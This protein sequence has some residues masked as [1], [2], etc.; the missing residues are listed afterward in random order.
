MNQGFKQFVRIIIFFS[1]CILYA[2]DQKNEHKILFCEKNQYGEIVPFIEPI[3]LVQNQVDQMKL[4]K[5]LIELK[6]GF[7]EINESISVVVEDNSLKETIKK[8]FEHVYLPIVTEFIKIK[9]KEE[10]DY[11]KIISFIAFIKNN[12]NE[13]NYELLKNILN[14]SEYLQAP[15]T[16][17]RAFA[18]ICYDLKPDYLLKKAE[19]LKIIEK[20][21]YAKIERDEQ[22]VIDSLI[23]N[24]NLLISLNDLP[25]EI[26]SSHDFINKALRSIDGIKELIETQYK[27]DNGSYF[28]YLKNFNFK[29]NFIQDIEPL[30]LLQKHLNEMNVKNCKF[31]VNLLG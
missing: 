9:D 20:E 16:V 21:D 27:K 3:V 25:I 31:I 18:N 17:K 12:Y 13:L 5:D 10:D 4:I 15:L 19:E 2:S 28:F 24:K 23:V 22:E 30:F 6:S 8:T 1:N 14:M 26:K 7:Q 11:F 29:D